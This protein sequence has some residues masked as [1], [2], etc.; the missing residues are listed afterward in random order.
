LKDREEEREERKKE[1]RGRKKGE[2]E[3]EIDISA[4]S[5]YTMESEKIR[6]W[7]GLVC[8]GTCYAHR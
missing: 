8:K 2:E 1:R 6:G 7:S 4:K 3:R 5:D